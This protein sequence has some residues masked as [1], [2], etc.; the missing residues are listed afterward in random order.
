MNLYELTSKSFKVTEFEVYFSLIHSKRDSVEIWSKTF[1]RGPMGF[2]TFA[3]RTF[4]VLFYEVVKKGVVR[5][6]AT[7]TEN[8]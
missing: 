8:D 4:D 1:K 7:K 2:D 3:Y 5:V 6:H